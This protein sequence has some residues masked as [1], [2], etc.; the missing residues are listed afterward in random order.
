MAE[1]TLK[2]TT[3]IDPSTL[4]GILLTFG[5]VA[6]AII[7]GGEITAFIDVKSILIVLGGTLMLTCACFSFSE[8]FHAQVLM[9]KT[10]FYTSEDQ[11]EA[12]HS[13]IHVAQLA[14]KEGILA[15]DKHG[16]AY[17][18]NEFLNRGVRFVIDG[19]P[20]EDVT[21]IMTEQIDAMVDRHRISA[22]VLR[23]AAE[24][25]P[26]MGLI[27]TLIGL[28]QMLGNLNDPSNIGPAMAVALLT[29][30]YGAVL[31]FM[32][33]TPLAA[34]LERISHDEALVMDIYL[35]SIQSIA[36]KENPRRLQMLINSNLPSAKRV[37]YFA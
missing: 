9:F 10:V 28:I 34:K 26:A 6:A 13:A 14:R 7:L 23:K 24:I 37:K 17:E 22:E 27:G 16:N 36:K 19:L 15:L 29:T 30:L 8:L 21:N 18:H 3:I 2:R 5:L 1:T 12:A 11:S 31:A 33:F 35:L 4:V 20:Q 32:V 25:A